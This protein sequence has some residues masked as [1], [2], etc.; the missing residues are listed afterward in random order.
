MVDI[1]SGPVLMSERAGPGD[2]PRPADAMARRW[3]ALT[4]EPGELT[5]AQRSIRAAGFETFSPAV[6]EPYAK[7]TRI[8]ACFPGYLFAAWA[9][10]DDWGAIAR[11]QGVGRI[12]AMDRLRPTPIRPGVIEGLIEASEE[13]LIV[14]DPR[15]FFYAAGVPLRVLGGPWMGHTGACLWHR[16]D[17][18]ALMLHLFGRPTPAILPAADVARA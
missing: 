16:R 10:G 3:Y 2:T 6:A 15:P 4:H 17:R 14:L 5:T 7:G 12:L 13:R 8:A 18:V 1:R 11:A 9:P